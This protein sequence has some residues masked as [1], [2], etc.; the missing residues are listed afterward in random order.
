MVC[1]RF[2][3]TEGQESDLGLLAQELEIRSVGWY[4]PGMLESFIK[5]ASAGSQHRQIAK[6]WGVFWHLRA[7]LPSTHNQTLPISPSGLPPAG[8]G[9]QVPLGT[10]RIWR[11]FALPGVSLLNQMCAPG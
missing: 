7:R 6:R 9:K 5:L 10:V 4:L 1:T 2:R 3:I 11:H 8:L